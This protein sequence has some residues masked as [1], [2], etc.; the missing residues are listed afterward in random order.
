MVKEFKS[1]ADLPLVLEVDEIAA[2][3][4]ISRALAY[5]VLHQHG[6]PTVR[7]GKRMVVPRDAFIA[8]IHNQTHN[9]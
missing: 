8:W 3:L 5:E 7:I 2:V 1:F 4:R 9:V 6:F